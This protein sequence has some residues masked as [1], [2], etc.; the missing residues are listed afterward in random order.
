VYNLV[1]FEHNNQGT[2]CKLMDVAKNVSSRG[3]LTAQTAENLVRSMQEGII[4]IDEAGRVTYMNRGAELICG[5]KSSEVAGKYLDEVLPLAVRRS[6]L[7]DQI[8]SSDKIPRINVLNQ[9]GDEITL[10]I[11]RTMISSREGGPAQSALVFRDV[12]DE[13]A[14]QRLRSYFL[15]NISHE[16]RTPLSALKASVELLLDEIEE[17]SKDET[18]ELV[19]NLHY[20]VTGLQT[21]IDNLLESVSIE[22]GRFHIK[23]RPTDLNVLVGEAQK[24][25]Q[26]LLERRDQEL[27][28]DVPEGLPQVDAD[29]MRL[30][31]VLV[32]LISN[33]SKYGPVDQ[34]ITLK[35]SQENDNTLRVSV[36]DRGSGI[37]IAERESIFHRFV[38]LDDKDEAQYGVGLGLSVVKAIV[39]SHGGRVGLD[40]RPG[41]GSVFWF[42]L[43][44]KGEA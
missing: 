10:A 31:Q 19:K 44:V 12:T 1:D 5:W 9:G 18:I 3:G 20:S 28:L 23:R 15:A 29:P 33:A 32:N 6:G 11:T 21:L 40:E 14:A 24:L 2:G 13:G 43:P 25:M 16:F 22:A 27:V 26:P 41:G 39:E 17:L 8:A 42:T 38:R 4:L 30:T 34:P 37:S 35:V 36:S 7:L